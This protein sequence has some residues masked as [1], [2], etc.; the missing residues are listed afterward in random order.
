[1]AVEYFI[2]QIT[3]VTPIERE[4]RERLEF[5]EFLSDAIADGRLIAYAQ[6]IVDAHTVGRSG[7]LLVRVVYVT[8]R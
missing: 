3:D 6:P 5:D 7:E 8:G 2:A 4:L 1:M